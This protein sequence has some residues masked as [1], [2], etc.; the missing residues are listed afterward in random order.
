[1]HTPQDTQNFRDL[2]YIAAP[3][4]AKNL[5]GPLPRETNMTPEEFQALTACENYA[6]FRATC[7]AIKLRRG[8]DYPPDWH[9]KMMVSGVHTSLMARFDSQQSTFNEQTRGITDPMFLVPK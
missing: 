9:Q 2:R 8:Y 5:G 3:E 1:M 7:D 4:I 6:Q